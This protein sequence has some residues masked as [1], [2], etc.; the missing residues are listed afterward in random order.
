LIAAIASYYIAYGVSQTL[1]AFRF[2]PP[3]FAVGHPDSHFERNAGRSH[4]EAAQDFGE[5][6]GPCFDIGA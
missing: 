6:D 5:K 3:R 4:V 1:N 2:V